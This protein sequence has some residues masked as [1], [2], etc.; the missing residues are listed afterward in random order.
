MIN[1]SLPLSYDIVLPLEG[2][3]GLPVCRI[4]F[5]DDRRFFAP[6]LSRLVTL[7]RECE[8]VSSAACR[9]VHPFKL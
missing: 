2:T 7:S 8:R 5:T 1:A 3:A 9:M 4:S 6:D